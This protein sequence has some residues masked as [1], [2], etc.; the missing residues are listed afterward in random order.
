MSP[1]AFSILDRGTK[2]DAKGVE[3]SI[4]SLGRRKEART[5]LLPFCAKMTFQK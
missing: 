5:L 2:K 4:F 1:V 3:S